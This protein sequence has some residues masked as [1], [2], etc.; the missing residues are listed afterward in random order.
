MSALTAPIT[1]ETFDENW[2]IVDTEL[3]KA[4][5]KYVTTRAASFFSNM[6]FAVLILTVGNG[7]IH[8]HLTGSYCGFLEKIPYFLPAWEQVSDLVLK[9]NWGTFTQIAVPLILVYAICFAVSGI[10]VLIVMGIYHPFKRQ[11]PTGTAK[12]KASQMLTMARDARR[13]SNGGTGAGTD[14]RL[15]QGEGTFG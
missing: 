14:R 9:P 15:R 1:A 8:D 4:K 5:K 10:F 3:R 7:L 2:S 11:L 12:E 13:Y 6:V